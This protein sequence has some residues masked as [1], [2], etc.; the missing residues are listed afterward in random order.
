MRHAAAWWAERWA[1]IDAGG[2][3]RAVARKHGVKET[4]L[5]WWRTELRRRA[6]EDESE[7]APARLLPVVVKAA[8]AAT[9]PL[10]GGD[11]EVFLEFGAARLTVRGDVRAEHLAAIVS[12]ATRAC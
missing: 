7:R 10:T 6:R 2:D 4:T 3:V 8:P 12:A 5:L 9:P 11:V 1:E